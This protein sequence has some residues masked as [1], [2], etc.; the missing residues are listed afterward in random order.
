MLA[1]SKTLIYGSVLLTFLFNPTETLFHARLNL[2]GSPPNCSG[3]REISVYC[4]LNLEISRYISIVIMLWAASGFLPRFAAIPAAYVMWSLSTSISVQEGGDQIAANLGLLMIPLSLSD[5]RI[6]H[7]ML[8]AKSSIKNYIASVTLISISMQAVFVYFDAA[9]SKIKRP[10]WADGSAM[11][12]WTRDT[13]LGQGGLIASFADIVTAQPLGTVAITWGTILLEVMLAVAVFVSQRM[14]YVIAYCA[15]AF[16]ILILVYFGLFTFSCT[17]IGMIC[18][19]LLYDRI[20]LRQR[21]GV[22]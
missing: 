12:Y 7:W 5:E 17:M 20:I 11:Y 2:E 16:H 3:L 4:H 19:Y 6:N 18:F 8:P 22:V 21:E 15:I 14:R 10:E 1:I 9:I 13:T